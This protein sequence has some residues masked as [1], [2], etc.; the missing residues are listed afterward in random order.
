MEKYAQRKHL[1]RALCDY[2]L[3]SEHNAK[4]ASL[5]CQAAVVCPK[6]LQVGQLCS[7]RSDVHPQTSRL[8]PI[9]VEPTQLC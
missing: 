4:Y 5:L 9:H 2:V 6:L 7:E 1:A 8:H 3:Y